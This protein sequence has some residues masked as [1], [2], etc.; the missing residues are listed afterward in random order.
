METL[1]TE[2]KIIFEAIEIFRTTNNFEYQRLLTESK[3]C[4]TKK[5]HGLILKLDKLRWNYS[6]Y[7]Q[8]IGITNE[9]ENFQILRDTT[10]LL[11]KTFFD[12]FIHLNVVEVKLNQDEQLLSDLVNEIKYL[13]HNDYSKFEWIKTEIIENCGNFEAESVHL[14]FCSGLESDQVF[15]Y[16]RTTYPSEFSRKFAIQSLNVFLLNHLGISSRITD[17]E[18]VDYENARVRIN[19]FSEPWKHPSDRS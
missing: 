19:N 8:S 16:F 18:L 17:D 7:L 14:I 5:D 12:L 1:T 4:E 15:D 11:K 3:T 2:T 13:Y 10:L 6:E 9:I